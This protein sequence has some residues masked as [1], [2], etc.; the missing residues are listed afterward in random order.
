MMIEIPIGDYDFGQFSKFCE[1]FNCTV[2]K[3]K[4]G[5]SYF[6]VE[7]DEPIN[8]FWLGCNIN[9]KYESGIATSL[10]S[11]IFDKK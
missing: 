6:K 4:R 8:F 9:F 7:S 10:S 2:Q 3:P 5:S 1:K 11:L